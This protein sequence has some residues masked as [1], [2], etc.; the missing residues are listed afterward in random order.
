MAAGHHQGQ[1]ED[2]REEEGGVAEDQH[3]SALPGADEDV[4]CPGETEKFL[5]QDF[6]HPDA[7]HLH[8]E[9]SPIKRGGGQDFF[10]KMRFLV[11]KT[12]VLDSMG[13]VHEGPSSVQVCTCLQESGIVL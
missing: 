3:D 10:L 1:E 11:S 6:I 4:P 7:R 8:Y 5:S 2:Y 12:I 13:H 9:I